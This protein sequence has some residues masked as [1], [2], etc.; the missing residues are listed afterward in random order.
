MPFALGEVV[1]GNDWESME[2]E[3]IQLLSMIWE[4]VGTD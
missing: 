2:T 1:G 3:D 4:S